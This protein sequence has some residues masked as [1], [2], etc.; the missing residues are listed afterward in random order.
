[1]N[2]YTTVLG[3]RHG[4]RNQSNED[5]QGYSM[6][7]LL[8]RGGGGGGG[9]GSKHGGKLLLLCRVGIPFQTFLI[10]SWCWY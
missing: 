7:G 9:G 1:M 5:M 4:F 10:S 3:R 8:T 6:H 2:E